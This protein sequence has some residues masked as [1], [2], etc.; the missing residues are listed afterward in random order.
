MNYFFYCVLDVLAGALAL[1]LSVTR[2][3]IY[4]MAHIHLL[5]TF[6][7]MTSAMFFYPKHCILNGTVILQAIAILKDTPILQG[8]AA[9][10]TL[11]L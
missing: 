5:K 7:I 4:V 1:N 2:L 9:Q 6:F 8:T 10:N 11:P 3:L